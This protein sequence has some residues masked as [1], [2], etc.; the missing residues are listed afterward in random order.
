MTN[1]WNSKVPS[2][3]LIQRINF[4]PQEDLFYSKLTKNSVS[5]LIQ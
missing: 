2:A 1:N 4:M 3:Q 5:A